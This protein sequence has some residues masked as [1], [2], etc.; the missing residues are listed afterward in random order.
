MRRIKDVRFPEDK[1]KE[2][3]LHP[4]P[5]IRDRA[6]SYFAKSYSHDLSIMAHGH[7]GRGD[8]RQARCLPADRRVQRFAADAKTASPG[9]LTN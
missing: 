2:A 7:Q 5:E 1:I 4:D 9:S 3:I 8:L 6:T